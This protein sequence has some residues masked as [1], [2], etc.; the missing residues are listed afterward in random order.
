MLSGSRREKQYM[1]KVQKYLFS[2]LISL[3]A[4]AIL[5]AQ[6]VFKSV[7]EEYYDFLA[8]QGIT[9]RPTLNY[10]TLSDSRWNINEAAEHPWKGQNL[11][12]FHHLFGD[13]R[14]RAYGPELFMSVNTAAPY[15]QR[16]PERRC[17]F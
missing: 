1:R 4:S 11:G 2:L 15:G 12:I 7:E 3:I 13:F 10:L 8:L 14:F 6:E 17:P 16:A 9:E 5:P